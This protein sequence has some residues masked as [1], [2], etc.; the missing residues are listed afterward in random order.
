[1]IVKWPETGIMFSCMH[2]PGAC[3]S[4]RQRGDSQLREEGGRQRGGNGAQE[5]EAGG[6]DSGGGV[7]AFHAA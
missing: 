7:S 5:N 2:E 1:M 3:A 4:D 6:D